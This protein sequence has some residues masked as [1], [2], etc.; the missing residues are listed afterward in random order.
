MRWFVVHVLCLRKPHSY[1]ATGCQLQ[2]A[3]GQSD[4]PVRAKQ[5]GICC[6]TAG[7]FT[8]RAKSSGPSNS[9][10]EI[11]FRIRNEI[12]EADLVLVAVRLDQP[13]FDLIHN[14]TV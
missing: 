2:L 13:G 4:D 12:T 8:R 5:V 7:Q 11:V 9:A 14:K 1:P 6:K 10:V 3:V